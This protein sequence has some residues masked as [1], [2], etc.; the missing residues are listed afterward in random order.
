MTSS[1][2]T[3]RRAF[4][5][6]MRDAATGSAATSRAYASARP[7]SVAVSWRDAQAV[8]DRSNIEARPPD[9]QRAPAARFDV[10]DRGTRR[11]LGLA[12][13]PFVGRVGDVDEMMRHGRPIGP[14]GFGGTDVHAPVHL[15]RVERDDLDIAERRG[16][17]ERDRGLARRGRPDD[18]EVPGQLTPPRPGYEPAAAARA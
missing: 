18:C 10:V 16:Y 6:S 14:R 9:E 8:D 17:F 11:V 1:A 4:P 13:R 15:H 7:V 12:D 2:R 5:G 3:I